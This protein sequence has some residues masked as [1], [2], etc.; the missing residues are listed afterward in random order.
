MKK[1]T[2]NIIKYCDMCNTQYRKPLYKKAH[3]INSKN[4]KLYVC[5]SCFDKYR[6]FMNN[7]SKMVVI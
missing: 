6:N 1:K 3:K 4:G 5:N 2:K 7:N